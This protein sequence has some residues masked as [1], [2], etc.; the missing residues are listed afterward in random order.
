MS[1]RIGR[2]YRGGIQAEGFRGS[3]PEE[4]IL[5]YEGRGKRGLEKTT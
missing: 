2:T 3:G 5:G 4:D 1:V